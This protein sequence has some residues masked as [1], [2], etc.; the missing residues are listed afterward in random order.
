MLPCNS[1]FFWVSFQIFIGQKHDDPSLPEAIS[2]ENLE[3]II[4]TIQHTKLNTKKPR[5]IL[6][7]DLKEEAVVENKDA[8]QGNVAQ[9]VQSPAV[10][11]GKDEAEA[12]DKKEHDVMASNVSDANTSPVTQKTGAE[13]EREL[14]LLN[15][16]YRLD[17]NCIPAV[18]RLQ[19]I[20]LVFQFSVTK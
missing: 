9:E 3:S 15:R 4:A 13:Y 1:V 14:Q 7:E 2:K 8:D 17:E 19:P 5:Q 6:P 18:Y 10:F 16:W 12:H 11:S 20:G